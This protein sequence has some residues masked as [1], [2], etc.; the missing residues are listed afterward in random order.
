MRFEKEKSNVSVEV[1]MTESEKRTLKELAAR[2]GFTMSELIRRALDE[3]IS[4]LEQE[5]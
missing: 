1:R 5:G 4:K 2:Y 3:F